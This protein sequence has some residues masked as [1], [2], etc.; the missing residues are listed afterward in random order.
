MLAS[1]MLWPMLQKKYTTKQ[2]K[3]REKLRIKKYNEYIEEKRQYI[4]NIVARQRQSLIENNISLLDCTQIILNR[5]RNLW[6]RK[7]EHDD[8]LNLRLG[9]GNVEP[10]VKVNYPE[11]HFSLTE[12]NLRD[13]LEKLG[14]ETKIMTDVP[15]TIN[16]A[17]KYISALIGKKEVTKSFVEGLILQLM[18]FH[19]YEDLKI[20]IM[21]SKENEDNWEYLKMSPYCSDDDKTIRFFSTDVD[22]ANQI[23]IYLDNYFQNRKYEDGDTTKLRNGDY[24]NYHPYF[25]II[26]TINKVCI[27]LKSIFI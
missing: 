5:K 12:N 19:S 3:K 9:I 18:A 24:K 10:F 15:V 20:I 25:L 26:L 23:S 22:E 6:E 16:L 13:V 11:E 27:E 7:I 1:M 8:F 14:Q 21:T 4:R 17:R 2:K